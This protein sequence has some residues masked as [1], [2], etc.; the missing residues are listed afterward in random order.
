MRRIVGIVAVVAPALHLLSDVLEWRLG[1]FSSAQLWINYAAFL[2]MPWLLLGIHAA[3]DPRPAGSGLAGA[4]IYGAA[5]VY[6]QHTTLVAIAEHAPDYETLWAR[7]GWLYTLHGGL[8]I[9]GGTLFSRAVLRA[10]WLPRHAVFLFQSGLVA[11][12]ALALVPAPA[13]LQ[14]VGSTARNLGVM[15]IGAAILRGTR[16]PRAH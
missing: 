3:H 1:G 5:F 8:M 6:F 9:L 16:P 12:L 4:L 10:G 7:L 11:N 15:A 14:T 2:P 13:I